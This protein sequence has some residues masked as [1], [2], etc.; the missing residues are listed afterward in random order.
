MSN[1]DYD[2]VDYMDDE[3]DIEDEDYTMRV[4]IN[5]GDL[6]DEEYQ[7][8]QSA[9]DDEFIRYDWDGGD[10]LMISSEYYEEVEEIL[11]GLGYSLDII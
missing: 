1:N 3:Y 8:I 5:N 11:S 4:L 6:S 7:E 10:R 2:E 9:L